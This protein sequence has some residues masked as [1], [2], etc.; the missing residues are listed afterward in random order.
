[1]K[2]GRRR[3]SA[4]LIKAGSLDPGKL[5][6]PAS[7]ALDLQYRHAWE[8]A[9]GPEI[10]SR[11]RFV[12]VFRRTL[13]LACVESHWSGPVRSILPLVAA[14]FAELAP[15]ARIMKFRIVSRDSS[16]PSHRIEEGPIAAAGSHSPAVSNRSSA[17]ERGAAEK[18]TPN[19]EEVARKYLNREAAPRG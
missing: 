2:Y 3:R 9:A 1:M 12:R 11:L 14:R 15:A 5:E 17:T 8:K 7:R 6:M 19:I 4:G 16:G 18:S 10:I 13:E